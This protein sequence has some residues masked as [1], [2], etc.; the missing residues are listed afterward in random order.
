MLCLHYLAIEVR[1]ALD[2]KR[3]QDMKFT[4]TMFPSPMEE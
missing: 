2:A 1:S 3:E 4:F